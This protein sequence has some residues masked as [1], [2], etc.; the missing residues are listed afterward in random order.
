MEKKN[1]AFISDCGNFVAI[2]I[3]IQPGGIN[4][5]VWRHDGSE[6]WEGTRYIPVPSGE[7]GCYNPRTL[8][9]EEFTHPKKI[10]GSWTNLGHDNRKGEWI[11]AFE[12]ILHNLETKES[13]TVQFHTPL[14]SLAPLF[15]KR[16]EG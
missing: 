3:P 14:S 13:I 9:T 8:Y 6:Y 4:F 16:R 12:L 11:E 7:E 5:D 10:V 1:N 2:R 15:G